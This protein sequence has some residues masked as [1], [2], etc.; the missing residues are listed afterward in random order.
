MANRGQLKFLFF[1]IGKSKSRI[2]GREKAK[3]LK[4]LSD[5]MWLFKI[6]G[7]EPHLASNKLCKEKAIQHL[8]A[9]RGSLFYSRTT[10]EGRQQPFSCERCLPF[11]KQRGSQNGDSFSWGQ[12][13][14]CPAYPWL[15]VSMSRDES[16]AVSDQKGNGWIWRLRCVRGLLVLL[17]LHISYLPLHELFPQRTKGSR[18]LKELEAFSCSKILIKDKNTNSNN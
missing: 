4:T 6:S 1:N 11:L 17:A 5:Q 8:K 9:R 2:T 14:L 18:S 7:T 3:D 13:S 15:S 12:G 16:F 10:C